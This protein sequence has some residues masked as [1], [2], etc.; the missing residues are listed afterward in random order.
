MISNKEI[1]KVG[2]ATIENGQLLVVRKKGTYSFI[3][4][5]GKPEGSEQD[6]ETLN[7]ELQEELGCSFADPHFE[8]SFS[9]VAADLYETIVTVRLYAAKLVGDPRP[10]SEIEEIAWVNLMG[11]VDLPLAPSLTNKILPH[12]NRYN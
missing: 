4:P 7:R 8:G 3:L 5:G 6:L 10:A 12:L 11:S 1:K 9:D 2:L